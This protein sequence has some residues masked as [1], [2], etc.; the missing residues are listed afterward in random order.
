MVESGRKALL[1]SGSFLTDFSSSSADRR[2]SRGMRTGSI[3]GEEAGFS[4]YMG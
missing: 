1:D 2:E 4:C 3:L